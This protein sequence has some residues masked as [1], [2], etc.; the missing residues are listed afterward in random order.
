M[1]VSDDRL[2]DAALASRPA[3]PGTLPPG[4]ADDG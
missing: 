2:Q 1:E 3:S 4:Y